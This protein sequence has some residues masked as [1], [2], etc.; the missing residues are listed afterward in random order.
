M[1]IS[2]TVHNPHRTQVAENIEHKGKTVRAALDGFEAELLP[3]GSNSG[4]FKL[5]V[6]GSEEA[7]AAEA[8]FVNDAVVT[9]EFAG[10][11]KAESEAA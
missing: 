3:I 1:K 9:A 7:A 4:T 10:E 6:T 2:F 5:R 11:A 8:L